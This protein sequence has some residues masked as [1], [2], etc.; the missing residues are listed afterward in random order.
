[1]PLRRSVRP[2]SGS[3]SGYLGEWSQYWEI[4]NVFLGN[5]GASFSLVSIG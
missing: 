5:R 4:D 1:M 3:S 2:A